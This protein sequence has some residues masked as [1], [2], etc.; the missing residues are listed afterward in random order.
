MYTFRELGI[1]FLIGGISYG[2]MEILFRGYTHWSM[3]V[4]GGI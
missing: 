4:T 3:L 1:V 2:I